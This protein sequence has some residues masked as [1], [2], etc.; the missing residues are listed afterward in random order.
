MNEKTYKIHVNPDGNNR[1]QVHIK[2]AT[3][4]GCGIKIHAR[5]IS[6]KEISEM[7]SPVDNTPGAG[8]IRYLS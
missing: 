1:T 8:N 2:F 7:M 3:L 5:S 4:T 6:M